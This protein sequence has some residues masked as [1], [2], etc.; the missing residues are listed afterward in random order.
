MSNK[1]DGGYTLRLENIIHFENTIVREGTIGMYDDN[2]DD[3]IMNVDQFTY[4][5]HGNFFV[6]VY[7]SACGLPKDDESAY[8]FYLMTE[9]GLLVNCHSPSDF[10]LRFTYGDLQNY[11][12]PRDQPS[13]IKMRI[14]GLLNPANIVHMGTAGDSV[15][16][17]SN[18]SNTGSDLSGEEHTE[19]SEF[20]VNTYVL[21][22]VSV[23]LASN[24]IGDGKK[25]VDSDS[26][27]DSDADTEIGRALALILAMGACADDKDV[28]ISAD[29][30]KD[31]DISA[32]DD[33]DVDIGKDADTGNILDSMIEAIIKTLI[34]TKGTSTSADHTGYV[35]A[36][37]EIMEK[38][39][40]ADRER[41]AQIFFRLNTEHVHGFATITYI[42]SS[43]MVHTELMRIIL[44]AFTGQ[45]SANAFEV[46]MSALDNLLKHA[47]PAHC[48]EWIEMT[49]KALVNASNTLSYARMCTV[50]IAIYKKYPD[51]KPSL[52]IIEGALNGTLNPTGVAY[53]LRGLNEF[54]AIRPDVVKLILKAINYEFPENTRALLIGTFNK[55]LRAAIEE[56]DLENASSYIKMFNQKLASD[57]DTKGLGEMARVVA[58]MVIAMQSFSG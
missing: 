37:E 58:E 33:K 15:N 42:M 8:T 23:P 32:D 10:Y 20:T 24:N 52:D 2:T 38:S 18:N 12:V 47:S 9:D 55:S 34:Q 46:Y 57:P 25:D 7:N 41:R 28:D 26:D 27:S 14:N 53:A 50:I 3:F 51:M 35:H 22:V 16:D 29:G 4:D 49:C 6:I 48:A 30:D 17:A 44:D 19:S 45:P 31:V 5:K 13:Q 40:G 56:K 39:T 21:D 54:K 1:L 43:M 36:F 11:A